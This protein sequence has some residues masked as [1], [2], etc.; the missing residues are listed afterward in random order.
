MLKKSEKILGEVNSLLL[1]VSKVMKVERSSLFLLNKDTS[2]LESLVA[3]GVKNIIISVPVGRGIVGTTFKKEH[4]IIENN[5]QES[6]L[7]D[8]SYDRQL[9]FTTKSVI[10]VPVFNENGVAIGALQ[11]LN[12]NEGVFTKKDIKVINSFAAAVAL[13]IKN[14]ELYLASEHIKNNF[15]TL[16]DVFKAVSSELNL[17]KLIQV[18]M[19]KA[20]EITNADR[21]SLFL[22]D[23]E[24][25]ELWTVFAKGLE[26]KTVRTKKGIVAQVAKSKKASIVN[27]PYNHPHFDISVDKKTKYIT[28]SIVSVP[29]FNTQN[30]VLGVIQ[31][32][33]KHKDAFNENDLEILT[34]FASQ[35]RIA[36]ENAKLFDQIQGIKNHLDILVQNLD[37]G[38]VTVDKSLKINTVNDTFIRM[39]GLKKAQDL[40]DIHIN[41]LKTELR[42]LFTYCEE[43]ICTGKKNYH[44]ELEVK[45]NSEK[46]VT[47][48]LSV[49]P[50][51]DAK[52]NIIGAIVVFND[53][54][55][56]KRIQSNLSRYIPKH[57]VK[58]VMNHD[59][60]S[61]LNGNFSKCSILFS[62][63]RNFTTLTEEFGAIQIVELLNKYFEAMITSVYKYNGILDKYIG[64]AI[65]TVFGVPY[66]NI[67]DAKN[68]VNCALDMFSMLAKLNKENTKL[69][70]LNI[71]IG[72]STGNVVS[73]NIG[74]KTRFEYTVIG[75]SVNLAARLESATKIYG[76]NLLI[77][78]NTFNEIKD[79]FHCREIDTLLVKGKQ[80]PVKIFS[81][82]DQKNKPLTQKQQEFNVKYSKGL[83]HFRDNKYQKAKQFFKEADAL[84]PNDSPTKVL[85]KKCNEFLLNTVE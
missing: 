68:A 66:A 30:K 25:G 33:N 84:M 39:F 71:G 52:E 8:G 46:S 10:C 59:N 6:A 50:M 9:H 54:S 38:I 40:T 74:S 64:D 51:Q 83:A 76:I 19:N 34:G 35:I 43:T 20:A 48:N 3:Q 11:C 65:M 24:T 55:Q 2:T 22:V 63:I 61:L 31:A 5:T 44:E 80:I 60:L 4:P 67:S 70:I 62:D 27:D 47:V 23:E 21:S 28:K 69:P 26:D 53:I 7:F 14:S 82:L 12:K 75:D 15:S 1:Q 49:L 36:I 16:L 73:G 17:N 45:I 29:V 42:S 56:E 78:E 81:V 57:L 32:I 58:E 85:L 72:I 18:V 13:I 37:N 77:C 79:A 41:A